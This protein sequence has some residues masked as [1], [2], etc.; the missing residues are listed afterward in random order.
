MTRAFISYLVI[1]ITFLDNPVDMGNSPSDKE[2]DSK[3]G[4][5]KVGGPK[6]DK[7]SVDDTKDGEAPAD[8]LNDHLSTRIG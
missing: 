6:T 8:A 7:D 4:D 1:V 3:G 5:V 2:R